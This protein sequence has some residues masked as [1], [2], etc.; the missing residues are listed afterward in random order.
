MRTLTAEKLKPYPS[1]GDY[2]EF[3]GGFAFSNNNR[4]FLLSKEFGSSIMMDKEHFL[5]LKNQIA[6]DDL[7]FKMI[8][9]GFMK[10]PGSPNCQ[11]KESI[12]PKF[13]IIDL[14]QACNFRCTYCFRH[15]E[16]EA[17][18]IPM[19]VLDSIIDFV[20]DYCKKTNQSE[21]HIQPWGGE[22]LIAWNKIIRIQNRLKEK[23]INA[24]ITIESNGTLISKEL[25]KEAFKRDIRIGVSIDGFPEIHN[26]QR[27]MV[28]GDPSYDKLFHG[29]MNLREAGYD[30]G[31]GIITVFT[32]NSF[33]HLEKMLEFFAVDLSV[34]KLKINIVK[35]SPVM[36]DKGLC[37]NNGEIKD[38]QLRLL[39][40]LIE[41]NKR[42]YPIIELNVLDKL[43]NLLVLS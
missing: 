14:T 38:F 2:P 6:T 7:Q 35:D 21:I 33:P 9:R 19:D 25:A 5:Q 4:Y 27:K 16:K 26:Q 29:M 13:F 31:H 11:S 32:K 40:K 15:L 10:V 20:A 23:E 30:L 1:N 42:G 8:Q 39:K 3:N 41:L 24:I 34:N 17:K 12:Q 22:P 43:Q 37:L 36:K 28:N 18:T